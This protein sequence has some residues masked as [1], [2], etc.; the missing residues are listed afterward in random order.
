MRN[1]TPGHVA[2]ALACIRAVLV[3]PRPYRVQIV[4]PAGS[5]LS[6]A[7]WS[8]YADILNAEFV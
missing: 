3:H 1:A 7:E 4:V 5:G 8:Q 2:P 6:V